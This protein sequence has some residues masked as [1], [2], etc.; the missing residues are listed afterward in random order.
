MIS[1]GQRLTHVFPA[2]SHLAW[3]LMIWGGCDWTVNH[4]VKPD[5]TPRFTPPF[6]LILMAMKCQFHIVHGH[7]RIL[8]WRYLPYIRHREAIWTDMIFMLPSL[9]LWIC[10]SGADAM[11]APAWDKKGPC[12]TPSRNALLRRCGFVWKWLVPHCTQWFCWS[13]SLLNGYNWEYTLFSD[14]PMWKSPASMVFP[15]KA[16]F[17][18]GLFSSWSLRTSANE[19][20][21]A[22]FSQIFR[23]FPMGFSPAQTRYPQG[24]T[25]PRA[26]C[27]RYP[28]GPQGAY[29]AGSSLSVHGLS[30]V[31]GITRLLRCILES[32]ET[33]EVIILQ[34]RSA[35]SS[36][37]NEWFELSQKL[38]VINVIQCIQ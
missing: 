37:A 12:G 35:N 22:A 29:P 21:M 3:T 23:S 32:Q 19:T 33:S 34:K 16:P 36:T 26:T 6:F 9:D 30:C 10:G 11:I 15:R 4:P 38:N 25:V 31:V 7:S 17:V 20:S 5:G 24:A 1:G 2:P 8:N 27:P 13:L 14:K 18:D 28:Q